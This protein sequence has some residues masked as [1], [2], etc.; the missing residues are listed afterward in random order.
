MINVGYSRSEATQKP[1]SR[2]FHRLRPVLFALL[3]VLS[4][5]ACIGGKSPPSE[6]YML[7]PIKATV[8]A[9][10]TG[11]TG[12]QAIALASVRMPQYVDRPQMVTGLS[13]NVYKLSETNR[14]AERLDDNISRVLAQNLSLLMPNEVVLANATVRSKQAKLRVYVA[15]LEFHVDP[16]GQAIL[17][18]QWNVARGEETLLGRQASYRE[19]ASVTDYGIM[20]SALNE[21]LNRLSRDLALDLMGL[22]GEAGTAMLLN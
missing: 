20:A 15:I 9:R 5:T 1:L 14:W 19:A 18:A 2:A 16:Q 12:G 4:L 8:D 3:P 6:F 13:K 11:K 22:E 17:T 7:E 10:I 21:C